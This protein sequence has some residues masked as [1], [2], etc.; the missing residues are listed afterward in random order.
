MK[1]TDLFLRNIKKNGKLQKHFD[2]GGL[3]L[4]VSPGGSTLWR[5][6]YRYAGK[7]RILSFGEYP[8]VTLKEAREKREAAKKLLDN[9]IDPMTE[10]KAAKAAIIAAE[11]EAQNVFEVV[12]REWLPWH[13]TKVSPRHAKRLERYLDDTI[14]PALGKKPIE[15]IEPRDILEI[16]RPLEE[17][18]LGVTTEKV[19]QVCSQVLDYAKGLS[20]IKYNPAEGLGKYLKKVETKNLAAVTDPQE[21]GELLRRID[22]LDCTFPVLYYLKILPYVFT[23]PSELRLAEWREFDFEEKV[24]R[25]PGSR[26]K[27][28]REHIVPLSTQVSAMLQE[29][30]KYFGHATYVFPSPQT[31][32]PTISDGGAMKALRSTGFGKDKMCLHGFRSMAS[33]RLNE[34]GQFRPDVIEACLA[35]KDSDA[36]RLAYNRAEYMEERRKLMQSW[37]DYLDDLKAATV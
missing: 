35:H 10:K 16:L 18:G 31:K 9:N 37:A 32:K 26:M 1:L 36:V 24:W 8:R 29:L 20:V 17:R 30:Y 34:M 6:A 21:I 14:L 28:R 13:S 33:T 2:G 7:Q 11:K 22:T 25:I 27:M 4:H 23:R 5:M 12:A 19:L 15:D 3:Y